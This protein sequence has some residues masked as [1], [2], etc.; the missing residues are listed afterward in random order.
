VYAVRP[1]VWLKS[2]ELGLQKVMYSD[3]GSTI[4]RSVVTTAGTNVVANVA[5]IV[6]SVRAEQALKAFA[7]ISAEGEWTVTAV[8]P[9][10]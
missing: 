7:A 1:S 2:I 9:L 5:G 10:S 4:N 3:S 6:M 8:R